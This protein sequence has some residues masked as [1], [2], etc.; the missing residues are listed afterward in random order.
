MIVD[1][2]LF[3][4]AYLKQIIESDPKK[5]FTVVA[6]ATDGKDALMKLKTEEI[7]VI[8]MDIEM[9]RMD[10]LTA[11]KEIMKT[12]PTPVIMF[13]SL[14]K[15]GAKETI[16]ALN[17]GA[18]DFL[19]KTEKHVEMAKIKMEIFE[20][21]EYASQIDNQIFKKAAKER[22]IKPIEVTEKEKKDQLI[23][24][25]GKLSNLIALGC[26]T[27]G[28]RALAQFVSQLPKNLKAGIVIVQHMP[29]GGFTH[30]LASHLNQSSQF[31][32]KEVEDGDEIVDG[33]VYIA[34]GGY[35]FE[36]FKRAEKYQAVLN[37]K[38]LVSGHR[39]S[40]DALFV[41]IARLENKIPVYGVV[42]TGMGSDGTNGCHALKREGAKII[43][44]SEKT[45][46]IYGM[47]KQVAKKGLADYQEDLGMIVPTL[48]NLIK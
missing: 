7:D 46:I 22:K 36:V 45:A 8:T 42:L 38:D 47:P 27:G 25:N 26:S 44:E 2:S 24:T 15:K 29:E 1:D 34:K 28:P 35:H 3:I 23:P 20:K 16:E 11:L 32:V 5:R 37:K 6:S 14:T 17:S 48:V 40:V 12:K 39:P 43:V 41:S 21:L 33:C 18:V 9:D 30:S 13:S 19:C 31:T 10:G 4:R